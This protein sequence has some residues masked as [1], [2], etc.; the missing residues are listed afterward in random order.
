VTETTQMSTENSANKLWCRRDVIKLLGA[1][2]FAGPM[3][4]RGTTANATASKV[5][6]IG[7]V[8]SPTG[9]FAPVAEADPFILGPGILKRLRGLSHAQGKHHIAATVSGCGRSTE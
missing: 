1:T 6:K 2:A 5:I 9:V 7:H 4:L 8:S 3:I